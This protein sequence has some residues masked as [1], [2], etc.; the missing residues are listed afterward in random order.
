M[1]SALWCIETAANTITHFVPRTSV[2][3]VASHMYPN[4][5]DNFQANEMHAAISS[6]NKNTKLSFRNLVTEPI[7][8]PFS[9]FFT[10]SN[11]NVFRTKIALRAILI[12]STSM[13]CEPIDCETGS[14]SGTLRKL[15]LQGPLRYRGCS[16]AEGFLQ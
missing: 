6:Y 8:L 4:E 11:R 14:K 13:V 10:D 1:H 3:Y 9:H 12:A 5:L 2:L 7:L 16:F 15:W